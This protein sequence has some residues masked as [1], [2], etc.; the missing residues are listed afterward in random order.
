[1]TLET[2]FPRDCLADERQLGSCFRQAMK[3]TMIR[4]KDQLGMLQLGKGHW[5]KHYYR[6]HQAL[7]LHRRSL[8]EVSMKSLRRKDLA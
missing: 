6:A 4:P 2:L 7:E 8:E 1:M 5:L 3:G